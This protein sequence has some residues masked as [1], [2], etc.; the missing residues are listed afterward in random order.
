MCLGEGK[1]QPRRRT[2]AEAVEDM[3]HL[4]QRYGIY[5]SPASVTE[6]FEKEWSKL[7]LLGHA[8]HD[9]EKPT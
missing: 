6:V 7:A 8:I 4:F 9:D 5:L 3:V 1:P 2:K